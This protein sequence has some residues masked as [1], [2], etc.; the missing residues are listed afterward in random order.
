MEEEINKKLLRRLGFGVAFTFAAAIV[1]S[2]ILLPEPYA[3]FSDYISYLGGLK[4]KHDQLPN[5]VSQISFAVGLG[6]C[7]CLLGMMSYQYLKLKSK[8]KKDISKAVFLIIAAIGAMMTIV[9]HDIE[10]Y[11]AIH[12]LGAFG[13]VVSL[14]IFLLECYFFAKK[15]DRS[16]GAILEKIVTVMLLLVTVF[17]VFIYNYFK[18]F[19]DATL[20]NLIDTDHTPFFQKIMVI[21][22]LIGFL[23]IDRPDLEKN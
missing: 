21:L 9:P 18:L 13:F 23:L 7:A 3:F 4:S 22:V 6:L 12:F 8:K 15:K 10:S 16:F 17:Y 11:S 14:D 20:F 1:V 19:P 5:L 2:W